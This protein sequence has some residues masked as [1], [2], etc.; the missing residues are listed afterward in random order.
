MKGTRDTAR[1]RPNGWLAN[2]RARHQTP[3]SFWLHLVGIPIAI[4]ALPLAIWQ[5]V[6]SRWDLWWRPV[7][8]LVGGYFLQ[9]LGHR[10]EGNDVGEIILVKKLL[11]RPYTAIAPQFE[12]AK[13]HSEPRL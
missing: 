11:G 13:D 12:Q 5:L 1:T 3:L 6:E 9:W 2:W 4:L 8:L 10:H 7:A